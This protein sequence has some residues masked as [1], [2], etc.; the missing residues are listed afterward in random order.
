MDLIMIPD[1]MAYIMSFLDKKSLKSITIATNKNNQEIIRKSLEKLKFSHIHA[2]EWTFKYK[3]ESVCNYVNEIDLKYISNICKK[4]FIIKDRKI[5]TITNFIKIENDN[6]E[7]IHIDYC[8]IQEIKSKSLKTL[9]LLYNK[10]LNENI[11][12]NIIYN[13][14]NLNILFIYSKTVYIDDEWINEIKKYNSQLI[15]KSYLSVY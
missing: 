14:P 10:N 11:L 6:V 2:C 7:Y 1:Y 15:I 3:I 13:C 8:Q 4:L 12:E 5:R 9:F